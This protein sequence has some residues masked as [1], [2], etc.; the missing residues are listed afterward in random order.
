MRTLFIIGFVLLFV[1]TAAANGF[2]YK[3]ARNGRNL[4]RRK[5]VGPK[6]VMERQATAS[7]NRPKGKDPR[8]KKLKKNQHYVGIVYIS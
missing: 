3:K 7:I 4:L 2:R 1:L 5:A 8:K 6:E